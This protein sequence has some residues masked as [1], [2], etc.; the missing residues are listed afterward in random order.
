MQECDD[1]TITAA[2]V[3]TLRNCKELIVVSDSRLNG[4]KKMDC[5]QKVIALP[6]SDAF[7]CFAGDTDWAYPLIHQV[8]NAISTYEKSATRAQDITTLKSHVLKVFTDL[9]LS[10]H[11]AIGDEGIPSVQFLFGGYSWIKK[12]FLIW[13]IHYHIPKIKNTPKNAYEHKKL[14]KELSG[15]IA[16]P[17]KKWHGQSWIFCGDSEY[18]NKARDK[19]QKILINRNI[20]PGQT[21]NFKFDWEPFEVICGLLR[22]VNSNPVLYRTA[23]IGG[24][25][26]ILKV[27]EHLNARYLGVDWKI[28]H[29]EKSDIY[30]CGRKILPYE[31]PTLWILDPDTLISRHPFYTK[32]KQ[33]LD[34]EMA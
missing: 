7:I 31:T 4:A 12:E 2:W 10:V 14:I 32:P 20:G 34:D 17:A 13:K 19:L 22:E 3:R 23:S 25:P 28:A 9:L 29:C 8:A 21:K 1:M 24:A 15:F 18:E 26:Q 6:R 33:K 30:V 27:Y 11:D 5:G 16:S